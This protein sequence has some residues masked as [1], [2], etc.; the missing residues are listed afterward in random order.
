MKLRKFLL[1]ATTTFCLL[2]HSAPANSAPLAALIPGIASLGT[3]GTSIVGAALS[4]GANWLIQKIFTEE[5]KPQGVKQ[6]L[7]S[8]GDNPISFVVGKYATSGKLVYVNSYEENDESLIMVI[9][10]SEIPVNA[11]SSKIIINGKICDIDFGNTDSAGFDKVT[12]FQ[13]DGRNYC[14]LKFFNNPSTAPSYLTSTFGSDPVK[15]WQNDMI[16]KGCSYVVIYFGFSTDG[17]WSGIPQVKFV[18]QG[19]PL[20]DPRKDSTVGGSGAHR[21]ADL[22]THQYT[23]NNAVI[24]YNIVRG[25]RWGG[26]KI[27]GGNATFFQCPL[28]IWTAAMNTCDEN[29]SLAAGGTVKRYTMGA[30]ISVD[31]APMDVLREIDNSCSGYTFEFGGVWKMFTG[32]PGASVTTISDDNVLVSSEQVDDLFKPLQETFN[33]AQASYPEPNA[34]WEQKDAPTIYFQDYID[35]DGE[36]LSINM[37]F[38]YVSEKNQVQRLMRAAIKDSRNQRIHTLELPPPYALLEA[39]DVITWNSARNG[40]FNKKFLILQKDD[41]PNC[42][43]SLVIREINSTDYDWTTLMEL[44]SS[45]ASLDTARP[46]L[47]KD[48]TAAA[49][50]IDTAGGAKDRPAVYTTWAWAAYNLNIRNIQWEARRPATTKVQAFGTFA[51]FMDG[52]RYIAHEWFKFN[53]TIEIRFRVQPL[54]KQKSNWTSWKTVTFA[55]FD[56]P[57]APTLTAR[58]DTA[59]DG[60]NVHYLV[61]AWTPITAQTSSYQINLNDGTDDRVYNA[62][63]SPAKIPVTSGKTYVVKVGAIDA[64]GTPGA[65]SSTTSLLVPKKGTAPTIP[66]GLTAVGGHRRVT[67]AWTEATDKDYRRT[68]IYRSTTND[69]TTATVIGSTHGKKWTDGDLALNTTYYYWIIHLDRAYNLSPKFPVSNTAGVSASTTYVADSD[70]DP[71]APTAPGGLTLTQMARD[72]DGDGKVDIGFKVSWSAASGTPKFYEVEITQGSDVWYETTK[73]RS[74]LVKAKAGF[75]YSVKVSTI[76]FN[77]TASTFS[78]AV[79]L[80]PVNKS[81]LAVAPTSLTVN[82]GTKRN[83]LAWSESTEKDYKKTRIYRSPNTT[84]ASAVLID[85][86]AG[87]AFV[88]DNLTTGVT[89]RYYVA[90][91]DQTGNVSAVFPSSAGAGVSGIPSLM[92]VADLPLEPSQI[93][94]NPTFTGGSNDGWDTFDPT[95]TFVRAKGYAGVPADAPADYVTEFITATYATD[96]YWKTWTPVEP[97]EV[98]YVEGLIETDGLAVDNFILGMHFKDI[99]LSGSNSWVTG[100]LITA[101]AGNALSTWTKFSALVTVP[102]TIS[103]IRTGFGRPWFSCRGNVAPAGKWYGT[104]F[105]CRKATE[106]EMI[107]AGA[108]KDAHT[109]QTAPGT[110]AAPTLATYTADIDG[111]GTVDTGLTLSVT[112]PSGVKVVGYEIE[113][114]RSDT[115][116]GTY[117]VRGERFP[118]PAEDPNTPGT[119]TTFS[120]K[121]NQAKY[122]KVRARAIAFNGKKGTW[123]AL[124][125]TGV[126]PLGYSAALNASTPSVVQ[127]ANGYRVT[128][129]KPTDKAY[130][131]SELLADAVVIFKGKATSFTD[132]TSRSVG[133][134]PVYT[135]RHYDRSDNV[136]TTSSGVTAPAY[137]AATAT[138]VG[139]LASG[140]LGA[141]SVLTPALGNL[142]VTPIKADLGDTTNLVKANDMADLALYT[143]TAVNNAT[144]I[145]LVSQVNTSS[146]LGPSKNKLRVSFTTTNPT[147]DG[148]VVSTTAINPCA[149]GKRYTFS[150]YAAA[151]T[152]SNLLNIN[153]SVDWYT[154]DGSGAVVFLSSSVNSYTLPTSTFGVLEFSETAP[155]GAAFFLMKVRATTISTGLAASRVLD[156]GSFSARM[157]NNGVFETDTVAGNQTVGAGNTATV[158]SIVSHHTKS[159][160]FVVVTYSL[161]NVSGGTRTITLEWQKVNL[162]AGTVSMVSRTL[163]IP[164]DGLVQLA[165]VDES[166]VE[167]YTTYNL[168]LTAP[169]GNSFVITGRYAITQAFFG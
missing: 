158:H 163:S 110:P 157:A 65:Y 51:N 92:A 93:I 84:W 53:Q 166:P 30:E 52:E 68:D 22:S 15:P 47:S 125:T 67:L 31:I 115:L 135:V 95:Y 61:V 83:K 113:R 120:F 77:G 21:W 82:P 43:Q 58:F 16:G 143:A 167:D 80:T 148:V 99:N 14:S 165:H 25:I 89:Y 132:T 28:D 32:A 10:L 140:N 168:R 64:F 97:G 134:Q 154:L 46:V 72:I 87:T 151:V 50:Q 42:N 114:Y 8:G 146:S 5:P 66:A 81:A 117:T 139:V 160:R 105:R 161:R 29:V 49:S 108:I 101:A 60:T 48:F 23:E 27:Y 38:P 96:A 56:V 37:E 111:D 90:H 63:T 3:L 69:F 94:S 136:G 119:V 109:D 150:A 98:Y 39:Y 7:E 86:V 118:V 17:I 9:N 121:A 147:I 40:Y 145:A 127:V 100:Y 41:L 103:S 138:E 126:S 70:T 2:G 11:L 141:G 159:A 12:Q 45:V 13:Q 153:L 131:E 75:L 19:I 137:R 88:D 122:W 162:I 149:E 24:S 129:T 1:A 169:G 144:G 76:T 164:D 34:C 152:N 62:A 74:I 71:T 156:L 6:R 116:G 124:T 133:A 112:A 26:K 155:T 73:N 128:W 123:S 130:K 102:A 33:V 18:V 107:A 57:S 59:E 4:L 44:E 20:Y 91:V 55:V 54:G 85:S 78:S 104:K 35:E 36:E 79:T 142:S 106:S